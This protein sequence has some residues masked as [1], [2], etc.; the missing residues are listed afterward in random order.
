MVGTSGHEPGITRRPEVTAADRQAAAA[1]Q[2][3]N[4][5]ALWRWALTE[6]AM[7]P[8][9]TSRQRGAVVRD[10]ASREHQDPDGRKASVSRRTIDRW[11][12]AR[13]EGGFDA[14]IPS[15]RQCPP[16][17]GT[18]T[19]D[20]AAGLKMENPART[21]AQVRR[22]LAAQGGA[23]PHSG[24]G[25][26]PA[27]R[28]AAGGEPAL[29]DPALL[30]EAFSW[31]VIRQVRKTATVS[32]EGNVYSVD[33]FLTGRKVECVFDPFDMTELTVYWQGRKV[34][35]A[36]PQ[37]IGRHAHPKA[38]PDEDDPAPAEPTGIDYLQLVADADAAAL[39]G[40]LRLSALDDSEP[41]G[42]AGDSG[43]DGEGP[44]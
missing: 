11:I 16:R 32:V 21:A 1:R 7:D 26:A 42:E 39:A 38:P 17:L 29:P 30:K 24:T 3:R 8:A 28:L 14:L 43:Q 25:Q 15:P 13:R 36:V 33:P 27:A 9:L 5:I 12:V 37:V 18:E 35:R 10:L 44:R 40:E 34:G 22:I 2:R 4:D 20:L 6:P 41:D 23:V 31:S 19:E